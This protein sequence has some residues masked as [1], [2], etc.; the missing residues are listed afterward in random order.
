MMRVTVG[1]SL[2]LMT[3]V[4]VISPYAGQIYR[5]TLLKY[6]KSYSSKKE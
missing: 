1:A 4:A 3:K 2:K 5:L 6:I